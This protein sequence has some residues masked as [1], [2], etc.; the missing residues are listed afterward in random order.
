MPR[1][2][3]SVERPG[4]LRSAERTVRQN[5]SVLTSE[6]NPLG[7]TLVND[8]EADLGQTIDVCL[9]RPIIS[10]F[11]GV[12]EKTKH[13]VAVVLVV[14]GRVYSPLGCDAMRSARAILVAEAFDV[15]AQFR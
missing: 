8:V 14:L 2:A 10:T 11:D 9:S 1:L 15:V 13:A 12:V 5:A 4:Y 6:R 3:S 7:D